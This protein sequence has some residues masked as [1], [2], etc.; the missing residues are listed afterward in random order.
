MD[1]KTHLSCLWV[2][3]W[4]AE[5]EHQLTEDLF[6]KSYLMKGKY[7]VSE[8]CKNVRKGAIGGEVH[9]LGKGNDTAYGKL[10]HV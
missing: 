3:D 2:S 1:F 5:I 6:L 9:K 4:E 10:Y 7:F 8:F